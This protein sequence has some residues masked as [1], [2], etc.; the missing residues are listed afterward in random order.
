MEEKLKSL[1]EAS[2]SPYSH[3]KVSAV[4]LMNDG[5][6]FDGVNVENASYGATVCAER[7]AIFQAVT[8]GYHEKE[9]FKELHIM[10]SSPKTSTCCFLCRQVITEFFCDDAI[11]YLYNNE[12]AKTKFLVKELCPYGFT[13]EDLK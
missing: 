6:T 13:K 10:V 11:I 4:V 3:F 8:N 1:Q 5:K 9:N 2:Y 7:V 12:G